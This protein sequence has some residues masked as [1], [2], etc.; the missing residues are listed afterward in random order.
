[1]H[2][3]KTAIVTGGSR[4]IGAA[5]CRALFQSGWN[6]VINYKAS[7]P[8]A[9]ALAAELNRQRAPQRA[10]A[11]GADVADRSQVERLFQTAEAQFGGIDL[12]V[13]NAGI[14]QQKLFTDLTEEDWRAMVGVNLDGV[15]YCSQQALRRMLPRHTGRII[16][17]ASMWG[18]VGASCEVHYSAVKAAVIGMTKAL[19]KEAGPSGVTVNCVCPGVIET[20]MNAALSPQTREALEAETPLGVIGTPED[21][22]AAVLFLAGGGAGF[23]TGQVLGVNGGFVI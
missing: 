22:A 16:N 8:A 1:M 6:V 17:I 20:D 14:A 21:V 7:Q 5:T 23:I 4:G 3:Q 9:A 15:F 19:A 2:G 10:V 13:N 18:Q 11:A 12:L